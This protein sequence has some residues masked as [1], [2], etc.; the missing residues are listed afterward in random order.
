YGPLQLVAGHF[1]MANEGK[2]AQQTLVYAG[3]A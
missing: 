3:H 2:P 1:T